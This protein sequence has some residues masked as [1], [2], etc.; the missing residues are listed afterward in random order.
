MWSIGELVTANLAIQGNN[1]M[2]GLED[3]R[4]KP[5]I[6]YVHEFFG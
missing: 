2:G 1:G 6:R 5:V 4:I 3:V